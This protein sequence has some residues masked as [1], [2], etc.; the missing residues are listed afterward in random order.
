MN[1]EQTVV[2]ATVVA[3]AP[4]SNPAI[5]AAKAQKANFAAQLEQVKKEMLRHQQEFEVLKVTGTKLEGAL[6]SLEILLK[7]L[8]K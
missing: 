1:D 8:S 6:E 3:D 7:G 4:A 5:D 2:D